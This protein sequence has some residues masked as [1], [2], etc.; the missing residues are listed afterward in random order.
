MQQLGRAY[1]QELK[2]VTE[3]QMPSFQDYVKNSEVTSCIYIL[4]ASIIPGLESVTQETIDWMK[5]E[6]SFAIAVGMI[7]RY[8]DDIGS[9]EVSLSN[10]FSVP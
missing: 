8:W 3:R 10:P 9:H 4:F 6:P 7:G 2:W 5:S 1:N